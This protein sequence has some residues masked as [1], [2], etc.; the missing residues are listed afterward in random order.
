MRETLVRSLSGLVY[1][2]L[3]TAAIYF[4]PYTFTG[5]FGLFALL[6]A[7]EF[8]NLNRVNQVPSLLITAA[9][10][11]LFTAFPV[12]V[13]SGY[14]L[15]ASALMVAVKCLGFLFDKS[16]AR[17][18]KLDHYVYL[19]GYIVLPMVLLTRIPIQAGFYN[20]KIALS[21]FLI[22]WTNDTFA[23]LVGRFAG[24]NKLF[25]RISPKKTIEGFIGGLG[26]AL[27][28]GS[29][30]AW[31]FVMEPLA[32]WL[33]V[34]FVISVTGTLGDLVESKFKR[35]AGVKDSGSIM[36][37]HGGIL[38]RLDSIIFAAPFVFLCFQIFNHVS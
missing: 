25:P 15:T 8:C 14:M 16:M 3:L 27:L 26:F 7:A 19:I 31:Y 4:S 1:V 17:P 5:L 37:G 23:Y 30:I 38:D 6:A 18:G 35:V 11:A 22:I 10:F 36:P 24:Q 34:A 32:F 2:V 20:P 12:N 29:L 33:V 28:T 13:W 9:L 21:L